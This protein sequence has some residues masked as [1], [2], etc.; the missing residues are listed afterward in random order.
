MT[1]TGNRGPFMSTRW[2]LVLAAGLNGSPQTDAALATLCETYWYPLY[3]F[4]R[5]RGHDSDKAA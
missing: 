4:L 1:A 5:G 2:S 3:A